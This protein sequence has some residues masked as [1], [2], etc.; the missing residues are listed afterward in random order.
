MTT[1][2]STTGAKGFYKLSWLQRIGY[3]SGDFAQNLIFQTIMQYVSFFY[4]TVAKLPQSAVALLVF[5]PPIINVFGSMWLGTFVDKH[6]PRLGKYRSY[7]LFGGIP[8]M[9]FAVLCFYDGFAGSGFSTIYYFATYIIMC[10]LYTVVSLPYGSLFASLTRDGREMDKLTSVRMVLANLGG[11]TI[12]FGVPT[13]VRYFSPDNTIRGANDGHAWFITMCILAALGVLLLIFCFSQSKERVVTKSDQAAKIKASDMWKE[14][15]NNKPL[16]MVAAF[17]FTAFAMMSIYNAAGA[18]YTTYFLGKEELTSWFQGVGFLPA[19]IF[20]PFIPAIKKA[21]GKKQMFIWFL[22]IAFVGMALLYIVSTVPALRS[23]I[24]MIMVA[25]FIKSTGIIVATGY[26]WAL[27]P[28]VISYGE[29]KTNKRMPGIINAITGIVFQLGMA[30]GLFFPNM[31]LDL[32]GFVN[33]EG[34]VQSELALQGILWLVAVIPA[35]ILF[36]LIY[37]ISRYELTD[38]KVD[39]INKEIEERHANA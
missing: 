5:I 11:L 30:I 19:F 10:L 12:A 4:G 22:A 32:V 3:G 35:L 15:V 36:A 38:E 14:L 1:Q 28:E 31:L 13:I 20:L 34:A 9:I 18:Y 23:Q 8:L 29:W 27:V 2:Q 6:N 16:R 26:M 7:M 33:V 25:Q 37:I 39:A 24:W 17:I 21:I